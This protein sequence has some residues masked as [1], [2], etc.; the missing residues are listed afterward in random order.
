MSVC[1]CVG[2]K[3]PISYSMSLWVWMHECGC[4][5]PLCRAPQWSSFWFTWCVER[6]RLPFENSRKQKRGEEKK[7]P[8]PD[9]FADLKLD[10]LGWYADSGLCCSL[11]TLWLL[12]IHSLHFM[13]LPLHWQFSCPCST[14][15]CLHSSVT[16]PL[17]AGTSLPLLSTPYKPIG[18]LSLYPS[19]RTLLFQSRLNRPGWPA[20]IKNRL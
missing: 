16:S 7:K 12:D 5:V 19:C 13:Q 1:V 6:Q 18:F 9:M 17:F 4:L 20:D 10:I 14:S 2:G 11:L 15:S 3:D 8:Q